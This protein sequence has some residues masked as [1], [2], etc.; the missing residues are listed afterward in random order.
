MIPQPAIEKQQQIAE[1]IQHSFK[2]KAES[3][4]LLEEA[5]RMVEMAIEQGEE[6]ALT[7]L[8]IQDN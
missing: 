4:P 8:S 3:E 2:L 6:A 1:L 7:A 5:K